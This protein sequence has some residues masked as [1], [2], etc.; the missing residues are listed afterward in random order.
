MHDIYFSVACKPWPALRTHPQRWV[1]FDEELHI[2]ALRTRVGQFLQQLV[3]P[4]R[5]LPVLA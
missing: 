1:S 2:V 3:F 4:L 5:Q